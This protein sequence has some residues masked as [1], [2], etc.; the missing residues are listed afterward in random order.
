M[1]ASLLN[2]EQVAMM[3]GISKKTLSN[4]RYKRKIPFIRV[5]GVVRYKREEIHDW[6]ECGHCSSIID[7]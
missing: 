7:S 4:W 5:N 2:S 3:L 1:I 6:L